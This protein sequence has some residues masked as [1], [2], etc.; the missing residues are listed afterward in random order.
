V[1]RSFPRVQAQRSLTCVDRD[2]HPSAFISRL[3][4]ENQ[5]CSASIISSHGHTDIG[6]RVTLGDLGAPLFS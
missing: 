6:L 4:F 2:V 5:L 3:Y 1:G